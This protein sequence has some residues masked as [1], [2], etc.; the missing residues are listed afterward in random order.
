MLDVIYLVDDKL[1]SRDT[2]LDN[3]TELEIFF[4]RIEKRAF[5][6][7]EIATGNREDA[8]DILQEAML[9]LVKKYMSLEP[10][11]WYPVFYSILQNL[12][13]DWYRRSQVRNKFRVWFTLDK[14]TTDE[15]K[16]QT[17]ID[18]HSKTA[19]ENLHISNAISMLEKSIRELPFRQQQAFMLRVFE[20][21]DVKTTARIM[22]CSEGSV[23]THYSRAVNSIR[24]KLGDI[25]P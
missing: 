8:L 18:Y 12:I 1:G 16:I 5:R 19:E 9:R 15:D 2:R 20:E 7:A 6:M 17:A 25:W 4:S 10:A 21:L 13:R 14:E 11:E 23:K 22:K 3:K 24:K